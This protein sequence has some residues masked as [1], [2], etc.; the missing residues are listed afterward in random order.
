M[1]MLQDYV[2]DTIIGALVLG[3]G[4]L[5]LPDLHMVHFNLLLT[6]ATTLHCTY[7]LK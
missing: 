6:F 2:L 3:I 5:L 1:A 7:D 4:A